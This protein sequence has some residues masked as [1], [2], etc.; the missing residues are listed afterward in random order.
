MQDKRAALGLVVLTLLLGLGGSVAL[1]AA[2]PSIAEAS[3]LNPTPEPA[4][5]NL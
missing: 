2:R 4:A 1:A 3:V 5:S